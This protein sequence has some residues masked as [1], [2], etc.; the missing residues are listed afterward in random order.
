MKDTDLQL[1]TYLNGLL[2]KIK[3]GVTCMD[4]ADLQQVVVCSEKV[5]NAINLEQQLESD[6]NELFFH[7]SLIPLRSF[8]QMFCI[9]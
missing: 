2:P 6:I 5:E 1:M 8:A 9:W 4:Y 3:S 7:P